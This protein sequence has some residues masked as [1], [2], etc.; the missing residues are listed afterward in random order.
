MTP[1]QRMHLFDLVADYD[2]APNSQSGLVVLYKIT[3]FVEKLEYDAAHANA[4]PRFQTF[5]G[6]NE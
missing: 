1:E 2:A 6:D 3:E 4:Y 5:N